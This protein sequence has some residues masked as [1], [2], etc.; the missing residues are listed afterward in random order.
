MLQVP[1]PSGAQKVSLTNEELVRGDESYVHVWPQGNLAVV[2]RMGGRITSSMQCAYESNPIEG[3]HNPAGLDEMFPPR[4]RNTLKKDDHERGQRE[5]KQLETYDRGR[6][7][8]MDTERRRLSDCFGTG[9]A[10]Q[11]GSVTDSKS[12]FQY[13]PIQKGSTVQGSAIFEVLEAPRCLFEC[14]DRVPAPC[15]ELGCT[16]Y[17][18]LLVPSYGPCNAS[19]LSVTAFRRIRRL[20]RLCFGGHWRL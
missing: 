20:L 16:T 3:L 5:L 12:S 17:G 7:I 2:A 1:V 10:L 8:L 9:S 18:V 11:R 15:K 4:D 13:S 19:P 6:K 14:Q